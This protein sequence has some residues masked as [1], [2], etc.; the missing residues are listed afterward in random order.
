M[1]TRLSLAVAILTLLAACERSPTSAST[2]SG[3]PSVPSIPTLD[4]TQIL[5]LS[6]NEQSELERRC[7]GVTHPTCTEMKSE[8]FKSLRDLRKSLCE[9]ER[10]VSGK[11]EDKCRQF[12][13]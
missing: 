7:L 1:L 9:T 10:L 13:N 2:T 3:A 12:Y 5:D 4:A 11:V 6:K 8:G